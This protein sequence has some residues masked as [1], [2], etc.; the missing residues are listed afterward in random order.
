[1]PGILRSQPAK[2][3]VNS[4][5][6]CTHTQWKSHRFQKW[7]SSCTFRVENSTLFDVSTEILAALYK[8]LLL[9]FM[10][11]RCAEIVTIVACIIMCW[12][13]FGDR[14]P[15]WIPAMLY[16]ILD[17][18]LRDTMLHTMLGI[19]YCTILKM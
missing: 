11:D 9:T 4:N 1:M 17:S 6:F 7:S 19:S 16:T 3:M 10:C 8:G 14:W 13:Q 2:H 5:N 18:M 12:K 15:T